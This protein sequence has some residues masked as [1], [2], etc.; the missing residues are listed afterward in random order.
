MKKED[1]KAI[2]PVANEGVTL[3]EQGYI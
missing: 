2:E 1:E 3:V